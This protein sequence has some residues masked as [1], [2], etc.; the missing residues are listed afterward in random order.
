MENILFTVKYGS[1]LYGTNCATSDTDKKSIYF[2]SLENLLLG[3]RLEVYKS[4]VDAEGN[5][6]SPTS[7]MPDN[8]VENEYISIQT[9]VKDFLGGQTYAQELAYAVIGKYKDEVSP[10]AYNFVS[11]MVSQFKNAEV[12][13]MVGFA[14]K[15][16]WDYLRR[17]ERMNAA[18]SLRNSLCALKD[19]ILESQKVSGHTQLRLDTLFE[20]K[21]ILDWAAEETG[22]QIGEINNN[23][24]MRSLEMNGRSYGESTDLITLINALQKQIDKYGVL[25]FGVRVSIAADVDVDYKSISHAIRVYQQ[26]IELLETGTITFP[27]PNAAFLLSVKQG[28]EDPEVVT[29]LL[30]E[31]DE[32]V[33]TKLETTTLPRKSQ[34]LVVRSEKWL[35]SILLEHYSLAGNV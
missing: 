2:P 25:F 10:F 27:R 11:D 8:G 4:R 20:G 14:K 30:D 17:G 23:K 3:K 5:N 31:L 1:F 33:Q 19:K 35:A 29:N 6:V 22:L 16:V 34:E 9:F 7:P 28:K 26:S 32:L 21:P 13:A 15:Q 18:V 24:I 12:M